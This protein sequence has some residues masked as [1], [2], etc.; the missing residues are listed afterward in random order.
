MTSRKPELIKKRANVGFVCSAFCE[1]QQRERHN[2]DSITGLT[3]P[4][5]TARHNVTCAPY[6]KTAVLG[7]FCKVYLL[8]GQCRQFS[9]VAPKCIASMLC[10]RRVESEA[11]DRA[12]IRWFP[13]NPGWPPLSG[14]APILINTH[15]HF[16][17][18]DLAFFQDTKFSTPKVHIFVTKIAQFYLKQFLLI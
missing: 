7:L 11:D 15:R 16:H 9:Q 10:S 13:R 12:I 17:T 1:Q 4:V 2:D 5:R 8:A 18:F 6:N 3:P 14:R